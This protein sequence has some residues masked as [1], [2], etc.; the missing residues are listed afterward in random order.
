MSEVENLQGAEINIVAP[1]PVWKHVL[2][3]VV[4]LGFLWAAAQIPNTLIVFSMAWLISYLLNPAID[5]IQGQKLGPIKE[6][7]RGTAVGLVAAILIGI[8]LAVGSMMLPQLSEQ[9]QRLIDLQ[10]TISNPLE[11]PEALRAKAEPLLQK[12][13]KKYREQAMEKGT[14]F[15][16][17]SAS[18]MGHWVSKGIGWLGS[19]LGQVLSGIF[20]VCTAF[21]ISM[22]MLM[23]WH[24]MSDAFLEKLPFQY[25]DEVRS[26][27]LKMNEIFGG[28]LKATIL[29]SIA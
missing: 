7:S 29:T 26:L 13:P 21:L 24:G 20:L 15:I 8:V 27:S 17:N 9:V 12:L 23:N 22:Y 18:K 1:T 16:Q 10:D 11:L 14:V 19:F 4:A 25:R 3:A 28:Y 2:W 5:K 6:C